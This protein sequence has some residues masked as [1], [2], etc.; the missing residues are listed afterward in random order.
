MLSTILFVLLLLPFP[1]ATA[2]IAKSFDRKFWPWFFI[3]AVLPFAGI[4]VLLAVRIKKGY[5]E[6]GAFTAD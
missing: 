2:F 1:F 6:N 3:G 5:I 4:V